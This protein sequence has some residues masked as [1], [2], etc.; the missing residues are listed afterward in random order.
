MVLTRPS[1]GSY[2]VNSLIVNS[3]CSS[4]SAGSFSLIC[5]LEPS[6]LNSASSS[7]TAIMSLVD[8]WTPLC[9]VDLLLKYDE[10]GRNEFA[11]FDLKV[12]LGGLGSLEGRV[13]L[14]EA[15]R[16]FYDL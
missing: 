15:R 7:L 14:V 2:F 5:T 6:T 9:M 3:G 13:V 16:V 8:L 4:I 1:T 12:V 10:P 11:V